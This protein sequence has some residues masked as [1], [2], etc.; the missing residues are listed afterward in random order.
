M[1]KP[2]GP[3]KKQYV[4]K[5]PRGPGGSMIISMVRLFDPLPSLK[6][7]IHIGGEMV[8]VFAS[9]AVDRGFE[10]RSGH[11]KDYEIGIHCFSANH[12]A[13]MRKRNKLK[14]EKQNNDQ[15]KQKDKQ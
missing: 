4:S 5:S 6:T 8:S 2:K 14:K 10:S 13:S 1:W 7:F 3:E 12:T 11:T 9:S 15:N